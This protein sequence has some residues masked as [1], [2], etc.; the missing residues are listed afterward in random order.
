M[1]PADASKRCFSTIEQ[2]HVNNSSQTE[3]L[4]AVCLRIDKFDSKA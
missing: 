2:T 1:P 4:F 3:F